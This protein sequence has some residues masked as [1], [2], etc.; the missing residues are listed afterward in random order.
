LDKRKFL[1]QKKFMA[2]RGLY[3]VNKSPLAKHGVW[4]IAD[5]DVGRNFAEFELPES[6]YRS[7][8][9]EPPVETLPWDSLPDTLP[10]PPDPQD[11]SAGPKTSHAEVARAAQTVFIQCPKCGKPSDNIKR[12]KMADIVVFLLIFAWARR[13]TFTACG[14]CMRQIIGERMLINLVTANI[15]W[16]LLAFF[17]IGKI[18]S[19]YSKGHSQ[20]V[21]EEVTKHSRPMPR[22][23]LR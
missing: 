7:D 11:N 6:M 3:R 13:A 18:V 2:I 15:C 19:S 21:L 9:V 1:P 10:D 12:Y 16:P 5:D 4:V 14:G 22:I 8:R 17:W 23:G 20:G